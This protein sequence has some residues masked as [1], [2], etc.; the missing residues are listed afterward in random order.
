RTG[1]GE[2]AIGRVYG[3]NTLGSIVGVSVASLALMPL[4]GLKWLL[5][6]GGCIDIAL[7]VLLVMEGRRGR[8]QAIR[9]HDP[10]ERRV[11]LWLR[12]G[13]RDGG[14]P[15]LP[16]RPHRERERAP[17]PGDWRPV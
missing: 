5:V 13:A 17:D 1:A 9:P 3:V 8:G 10:H 14:R 15:L 16:R 6:L 4:L 7:G 12:P 2:R 11:P